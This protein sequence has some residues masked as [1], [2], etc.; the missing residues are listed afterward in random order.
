MLISGGL[1]GMAGSIEVIGKSDCLRQ[2]FGT[3]LG[4]DSL[5]V[6]L[7]GGTNPFGVLPAGLFFGALRAGMQTMQRS[8]GFPVLCWT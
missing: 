7:L 6:A 5:A 3:N 4:F 1:C 8:L 2:G